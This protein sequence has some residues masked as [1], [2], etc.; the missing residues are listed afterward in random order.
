MS[1]KYYLC[2]IVTVTC[3]QYH[4]EYCCSN[5]VPWRSTRHNA[6]SVIGY[7][8][9]TYDIDDN[10]HC[11]TGNIKVVISTGHFKQNNP[12][13]IGLTHLI[14]CFDNQGDTVLYS[15]EGVLIWTKNWYL[16]HEY[17]NTCKGIHYLGWWWCQ[18][19]VCD[20]PLY[21]WAQIWSL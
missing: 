16:L 6:T 10:D 20:S 1:K 8:Q 13:V 9:N 5:N 11:Y 14:G 7:Y 15:N 3:H 19:E 18:H 2:N 4:P 17:Q 12:E 21:S